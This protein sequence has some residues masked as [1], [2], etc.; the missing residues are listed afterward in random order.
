MRKFTHS[1]IYYLILKMS[2]KARCLLVL[3]VPCFLGGS[4]FAMPVYSN[5]KMAP[6]Y[7]TTRNVASTGISPDT[8]NTEG[9][10]AI[11]TNSTQYVPGCGQPTLHV[12]G[13]STYGCAWPAPR[14]PP[15]WA[16]IDSHNN[17]EAGG[18][19]YTAVCVTETVCRSP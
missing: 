11:V 13:G 1:T 15:G 18:D 14:C 2:L 12:N 10:A 3:L 4:T 16:I 7:V 6:S 5:S 9:C 19:A 17:Q 8:Q